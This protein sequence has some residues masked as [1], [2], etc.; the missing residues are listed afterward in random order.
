M[1]SSLRLTYGAGYGAASVWLALAMGLSGCGPADVEVKASCLPGEA[2]LLEAEAALADA[3][4]LGVYLDVSQ[5]S[6]N[7]GRGQG[8]S[9]YR[10]LIAWLLNLTAEFEEAQTYGFAEGIAAVDSEVFVQAARGVTNPCHNC[11]FRES[12]LDEVLARL[13]ARESRESFN[14]VVT[15][16]W[17]D[18]SELVG[19]A[20][21]A[22]LGPIRKILADGRA[23]GVLG[24][25]A[26]YSGQVY[27]IPDSAG[28]T[29]IPAGQVSQRPVFALLIGP[30]AQ[31]IALEQRL[32][33][34]VL[35][36]GTIERHFVLFTPALA[37][38]GPTELRLTA[39][40]PAVRQAYVLRIE[41]KNEPGFEIDRGAI[42][43][44]AEMG[45]GTGVYLTA[46][47]PHPRDGIPRSSGYELAAEMWTLWPPE[48]AKACEAGAWVPRDTEGALD[49][50]RLP[51]RSLLAGQRRAADEPA[52][53]WMVRLAA[54]RLSML[55]PGDIAF[56]RYRVALGSLERGA[57][58]PDEWNFDAEDA[59]QHVAEPPTPFP[60]LHLA[61]FGRILELAMSEQVVGEI[62]A[63]G[64]VQIKVE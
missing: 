9:P 18:N 46:P 33:L 23:I 62:I 44:Y 6:T 7:F 2:E 3:K 59:R 54:S 48:P 36:E 13:A 53:G 24:V 22:L 42:N 40:N 47:I 14:V 25:T 34:D 32:T 17:L 4:Q 31:V 16:L 55:Q 45:D 15:D 35:V 37:A 30:P 49:V 39:N 19:N 12:R 51:D 21:L 43:P 29:T 8:E 60:A 38:T 57:S 56:L 41:G 26:P 58:F 20:R 11:G 50:L 5:S 61:E 1:L 10:N 27:E 52:P 28:T 64:N 63:E